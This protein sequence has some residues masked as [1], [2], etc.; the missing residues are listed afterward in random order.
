MIV[1]L[2]VIPLFIEPVN[3]QVDEAYKLGADIVELHTG[4]FCG[5][6]GKNRY[7]EFQ[8]LENAVDHATSLGVEVHAGHGLD[9][10]TTSIISKIRGLKELNIGHSIISR[11]ITV[12][13]GQATKEML[14]QMAGYYTE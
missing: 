10:E 8:R 12:G 6:S 7:S 14:T 11:A 4:L 5:L 9:F 1:L 3:D 2:K 13:L